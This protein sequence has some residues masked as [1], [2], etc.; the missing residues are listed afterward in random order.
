[1]KQAIHPKKSMRTYLLILL[2]YSFGSTIQADEQGDYS[3]Y[4]DQILRIEE[5]TSNENFDESLRLYHELFEQYEYVFVR[6]AYNACQIA[7]LTKHISFSDFFFQCAKSGVRLNL[8]LHNTHISTLYKSDSS[9]LNSLFLNGYTI[10]SER[11]DTSLRNE[12]TNRFEN[13]Q[14]NKGKKNYREICTDNFTRIYELAKQNRFPGENII[15]TD[16]NLENSFVLATLLH[17]PYSYTLLEPYLWKAVQSGQAQPQMILYLYSF[18]QTRTSILYDSSIPVD[19]VNFKHCYNIAFGKK[20]DDITEVNRQRKT[21]QIF[22]V[23]TEK[24]L[25]NV[26]SK[27]RI[28]YR[29]GY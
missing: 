29:Y 9:T 13:E 23:E 24:K 7:A 15:G 8:L 6:D 16:A 18:N 17:Y 1:M 20:S 14:K 25:Q 27:Y 3:R 22:S 11:L 2:F 4:F 5:A 10:Y 26:A 21:R 19:T 12:F 28:D